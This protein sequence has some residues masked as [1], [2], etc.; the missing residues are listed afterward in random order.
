LNGI[1]FSLWLDEILIA[2]ATYFPQIPSILSL[3]GE[4]HGFQPVPAS[5]ARL[6]RAK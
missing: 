6:H 5:Q 2:A 1:G 3:A 4:N